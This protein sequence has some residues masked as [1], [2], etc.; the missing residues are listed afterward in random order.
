MMGDRQ[1]FSMAASRYCGAASRLL[2]RM[3]TAPMGR[4]ICT[5]AD[6]LLA[7]PLMFDYVTFL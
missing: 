6:V 2:C 4:V 3:A 5:I 7:Q 1:D